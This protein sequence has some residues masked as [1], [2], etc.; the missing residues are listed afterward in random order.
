MDDEDI[1]YLGNN[2]K[3][4]VV[5]C[6]YWT[7]YRHGK[8]SDIIQDKLILYN[9]IDYEYLF[10]EW[11]ILNEFIQSGMRNYQRFYN[12]SINHHIIRNYLN[13]ISQKNYI[14]PEIVEVVIVKDGDISYTTCI[15]KTFWL[16]IFQRKFKNY[17]KKKIQFMRNIVNLRHRELHGR[18]PIFT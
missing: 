3:Y 8:A 13:I 6:E 14:Q 12:M 16:R 10:N 11:L 18:F 15:K 1:I 4:K 9:Y 2:S 17:Y 5:L 7:K